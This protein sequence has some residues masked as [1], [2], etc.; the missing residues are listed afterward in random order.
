NSIGHN[1]KWSNGR[2]DLQYG[3]GVYANDVLAV[4]VKGE[5]FEVTCSDVGTVS[6]APKSYNA[7]FPF[8]QQIWDM[9][10][11][12]YSP[13]ELKSLLYLREVQL[14]QGRFGLTELVEF[15]H[16]PPASLSAVI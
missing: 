12:Q 11:V 9:M 4:L 1:D 15:L 6:I 14:T 8:V 7:R 16:Y 5:A 2:L 13:S 10:Q 3:Q